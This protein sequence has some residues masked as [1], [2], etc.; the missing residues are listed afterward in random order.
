MWVWYI[1]GGSLTC[2]CGVSHVVW[3]GSGNGVTC[4]R[5]M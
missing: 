4:R 2:V 5:C 1:I 3:F